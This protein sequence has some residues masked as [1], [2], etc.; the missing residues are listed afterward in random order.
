MG[1]YIKSQN[2]LYRFRVDTAQPH[3]YLL[4]NKYVYLADHIFRFRKTINTTTAR[5]SSTLIGCV[6]PGICFTILGYTGC[7]RTYA[8][9]LLVIAVTSCGG[10]WTG[11][12]SNHIDIAPNFAGTLMG[13][14]N[15]V[16][17]IPGMAVGP[18]VGWITS[19][20]KRVKACW[21]NTLIA[22]IFCFIDTDRI[23]EDR[24][25]Y[26]S[27]GSIDWSDFLYY[28][29]IGGGAEVESTDSKRRK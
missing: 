19:D 18:F 10:M 8:V 11:F 22:N 2:H 26:G 16:A 21:V 14:I 6:I 15:T 25:F 13:M 7:N 9:T 5:K 4:I 17:T 23:L 29:C 1:I 24:I 20:D 3:C 28:I 12:L 27:W